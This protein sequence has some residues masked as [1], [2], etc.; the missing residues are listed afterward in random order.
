M[1]AYPTF[2]EFRV[3]DDSVMIADMGFKK[4]L[5]SLDPELD[6]VWDWGTNNWEIWQFP[7]QG[8]KKKKV[9]DHRAYYVMKVQ[10]ENKSFRQLGADILLTLQ[11]N[12]NNRFSAKQ[13]EDYLLKQEENRRRAINNRLMDKI[14]SITLDARD[15]MRGVLKIQVPRKYQV[16]Q[17]V[18][19]AVHV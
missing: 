18:G 12:D 13:I 5:W 8:D 17:N 3:T 15:Y 16:I 7:G 2:K 9:M 6:V 4:Q 10:G 14:G 1:G 11:K 19:A